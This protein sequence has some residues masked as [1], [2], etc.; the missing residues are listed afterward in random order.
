MWQLAA[1]VTPETPLPYLNEHPDVTCIFTDLVG[2]T[3]WVQDLKPAVAMQVLQTYFSRLDA[4][5]DL[6]GCFKYQTVSNCGP[7]EVLA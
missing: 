5:M 3:S 6:T 4:L 7:N 2:F 1:E